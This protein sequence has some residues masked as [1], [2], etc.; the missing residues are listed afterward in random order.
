M[1]LTEAILNKKL[2]HCSLYELAE[3]AATIIASNNH[4]NLLNNNCQNFCNKFLAAHS[5]PLYATDTEI[6]Q[7]AG[8]MVYK[9]ASYL[10][11]SSQQ[12]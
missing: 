9:A 4:Y 11:G 2:V 7:S 5:L 12:N 3:T 6:L 8:G 10:R 1:Q